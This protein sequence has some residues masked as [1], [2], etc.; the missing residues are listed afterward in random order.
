MGVEMQDMSE[1]NKNKMEIE[2]KIITLKNSLSWIK[3][4]VGF[5]LIAAALIIAIY[6]YKRL[7]AK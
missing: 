4:V 3:G 6:M 1:K 5:F 7:R 2:E